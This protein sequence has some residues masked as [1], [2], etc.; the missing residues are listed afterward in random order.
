MS[1]LN[2]AAEI[3]SSRISNGPSGIMIMKS[4]MWVNCTPAS[5]KSS[6]FSG[7]FGVND[8]LANNLRHLIN[9]VK[10]LDA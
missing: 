6:G 1:A 3:P 8:T 4:M 9:H 5:R 10:Y 2:S 7:I